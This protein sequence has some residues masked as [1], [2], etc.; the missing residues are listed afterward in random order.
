MLQ[1]YDLQRN[2]MSQ[3]ISFIQNKKDI[4]KGSLQILD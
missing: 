4:E 1:T 2:A 3:S